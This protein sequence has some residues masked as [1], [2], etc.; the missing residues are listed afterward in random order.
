MANLFLIA[1]VDK[2]VIE[3]VKRTE[4]CVIVHHTMKYKRPKLGG[5][6]CVSNTCNILNGDLSSIGMI[7]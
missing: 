1:N 2:V 6:H 4:S 3:F 5:L 7:I